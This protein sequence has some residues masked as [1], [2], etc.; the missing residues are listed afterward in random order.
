M[1]RYFMTIPEAVNL[2]IHAAC[3]TTGGDLFMLRM[4]EVV[5]IVELAERMIRLRGLVPHKDVPIR[6]VGLRPGE[7]VHEQ[8]CSDQEQ[9]IPTRHP[10][11]VELVSRTNGLHPVS[12]ADRLDRL[13]QKGLDDNQEPLIQLREIIAL[14]E[15]HQF[16]RVP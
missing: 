14:G 3:L 8:L 4:G 10:H 11:I 6:Y 12:F 2:V 13:F 16:E 7:K 1:T 9:E 5:R 15:P